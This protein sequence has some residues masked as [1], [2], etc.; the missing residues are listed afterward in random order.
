[1]M[2]GGGAAACGQ[3]QQ[4]SIFWQ[5]SNFLRI[6][7]LPTLFFSIDVCYS[8]GVASPTHKLRAQGLWPR[9]S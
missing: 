3:Q 6:L 7:A 1:M 9:S 8:K 2:R 4:E 5:N